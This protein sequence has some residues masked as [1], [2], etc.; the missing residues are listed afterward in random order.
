[1]PL[2]KPR[3][4]GKVPPTTV[5]TRLR[6]DGSCQ[7]FIFS[8]INYN[9]CVANYRND[10]DFLQGDWHLYLD[11]TTRLWKSKREVIQLL[12]KNGKIIDSRMYY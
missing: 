8:R 5:P 3:P 4:R 11:R 2:I 12:D 10:R 1:M 6:S 9:Q 7:A